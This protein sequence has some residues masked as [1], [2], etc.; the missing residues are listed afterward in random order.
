VNA[1]SFQ[2]Q[3]ENNRQSPTKPITVGIR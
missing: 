1:F 2:M 3:N